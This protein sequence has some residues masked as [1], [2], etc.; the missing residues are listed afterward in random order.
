MFLTIG[1]SPY[2]KRATR[3]GKVPI[4]KRGIRK[5]KSAKEWIVCNK[6]VKIM[7]IFPIK[8]NL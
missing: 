1:R 3:D 8:L 7:T 6:P 2:R 5:H 4:P